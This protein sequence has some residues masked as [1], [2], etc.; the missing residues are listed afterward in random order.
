MLAD[1][2][3]WRRIM[4]DAMLIKPVLAVVALCGLALP[5][6]ACDGTASTLPS[7]A[8]NPPPPPSSSWSSLT[9]DSETFA[10]SGGAQGVATAK[11]NAKPGSGADP[12]SNSSA[13]TKAAHGLD[14]DF[15][16]NL[17]MHLSIAGGAFAGGAIGH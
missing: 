16:S 2:L 6:Q 3:I 15:G 14:Y 12:A 7:F 8:L 5:A 1:T 17:H 11:P 13:K 9:A 4:A 10:I